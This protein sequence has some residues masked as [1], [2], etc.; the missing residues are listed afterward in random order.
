MIV[1]TKGRN[2]AEED[3]YLRKLEKIYQERKMMKRRFDTRQNMDELIFAILN[4]S[5]F[6][7][8]VAVK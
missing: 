1:P 8:Q 7:E 2:S 6:E 4:L 3:E 5:I